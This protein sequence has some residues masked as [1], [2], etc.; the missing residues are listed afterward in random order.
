MCTS[1]AMTLVLSRATIRWSTTLLVNWSMYRIHPT[2]DLRD[3]VLGLDEYLSG[4]LN[5]NGPHF[6]LV[7][8]R[9]VQ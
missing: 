4:L 2:V 5:S 3:E 9:P 6:F 8:F 1:R 7:R